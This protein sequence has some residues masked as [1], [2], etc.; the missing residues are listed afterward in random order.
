MPVA[1]H[2]RFR[3]RR[4]PAR[5]EEDGDV[6][7]IGGR[8]LGRDRRLR[9]LVP[10]LDRHARLGCALRDHEHLVVVREQR[11]PL[12]R[13]EPV[14]DRDQGNAGPG[15]GE[16]RDR[17]PRVAR[18]DVRQVLRPPAAQHR[19]PRCRPVQQLLVG[20]VLRPWAE[21]EAVAEGGRHHLEQ[22]EQGHAVTPRGSAACSRR[23]GRRRWPP[24]RPRR[25]RAPAAGRPRRAAARTPRG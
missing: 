20:Q 19:R 15:S 2:D 7:S 6:V 16:Q 5:V 11:L 8:R 1:Q 10:R 25:R 17:K 12:L 18:R 3:R 24:P 13:R 9:R 4:R 21:G 14:V 22:H 23:S